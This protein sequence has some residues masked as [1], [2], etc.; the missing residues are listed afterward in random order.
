M[1]QACTAVSMQIYAYERIGSKLYIYVSD[2]EGTKYTS[3][4]AHVGKG[5]LSSMRCENNG[6][7]EMKIKLVCCAGILG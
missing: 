5:S 4:F 7:R 6:C 3:S 1:L 2:A